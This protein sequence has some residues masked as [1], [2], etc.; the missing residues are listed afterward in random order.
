V[1]AATQFPVGCRFHNRCPYA[2]PRCV[3]EA[4]PYDTLADAPAHG[5]SCWEYKNIP[6]HGPD[7]LVNTGASDLHE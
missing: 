2:Q 4:P 3:E 5:V 6:A 1:P 7:T